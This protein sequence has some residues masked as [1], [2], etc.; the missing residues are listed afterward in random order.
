MPDAENSPG[1]PVLREAQGGGIG[2]QLLA[3]ALAWA[4]AQ[5]TSE[6]WLGVW[7]HNHLA[8]KFYAQHG[9]E[10]VGSHVFMLGDDAQTDLILR[11]LIGT[12]S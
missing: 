7:E 11:R 5:G 9:F 4:E 10:P 2:A 8:L 6:L 1:F 12:A 3:W